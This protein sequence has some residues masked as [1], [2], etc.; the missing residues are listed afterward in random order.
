MQPSTEKQWCC[1]S[2]KE[3]STEGT[4]QKTQNNYIQILTAKNSGAI[5]IYITAVYMRL[6]APWLRSKTILV[7]STYN[8]MT[9]IFYVL[10]LTLITSGNQAEKP[11]LTI[12]SAVLVC[13]VWTQI[14]QREK[15]S[16]IVQLMMLSTLLK[17][18]KYRF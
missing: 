5:A 9:K 13:I 3:G 12:F 2:L 7:I 4:V 6:N 16:V 15:L 14:S 11:I 18:L 10:T 1:Y 8:Q 17:N